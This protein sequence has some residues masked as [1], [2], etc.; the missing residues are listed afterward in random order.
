MR[1][2]RPIVRG[3][4]RHFCSYHLKSKSNLRLADLRKDFD[5]LQGR[6][7]QFKNQVLR[8]ASFASLN[9]SRGKQGTPAGRTPRVGAGDNG[10]ARNDREAYKDQRRRLLDAK[11]TVDESGESMGRSQQAIE[12][13][14][15]RGAQ[16]TQSLAEQRE[17][18]LRARD[19]IHSTD[20]FLVKSA[21]TLRRMKR[22]IMTNKL[23]QV[24]IRIQRLR[25]QQLLNC[26]LSHRCRV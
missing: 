4:C 25:S 3:E 7:N 13:T 15:E 5:N 1:T 9:R 12:E 20:D 16:T 19:T 24:G 14:L 17:A 6:L 8:L 18:L 22:R 10:M 26:C 2:S 23:I 11:G 21:K